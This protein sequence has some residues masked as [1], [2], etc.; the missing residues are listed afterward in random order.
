MRLC[1]AI[2][3]PRSSF[4]EWLQR[5]P[6]VRAIED[7]QLLRPLRKA[8]AAH[9]GVHG[10][11]RLKQAFDRMGKPCGR[12]RVARLVRENGLVAKQAR[13]FRPQPGRA[14]HYQVP[15][16]LLE[17]E[18]ATRKRDVW[19]RDYTYIHTRRG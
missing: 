15:N 10:S 12:H 13:R 4:Y 5:V 9:Q 2:D 8:F 14:A 18:P 1:G 6:S 17:R 7:A 11:P 16:R 3:V 19:V